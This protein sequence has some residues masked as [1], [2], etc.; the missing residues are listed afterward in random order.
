MALT[1]IIT[2]NYSNFRGVD[3][4]NDNAALTRSPDAL[5][6][7]RNYRD[8]DC[9]QTRPGMKLLD[10]FGNDI[11]GLF[12]YEKEDVTEVLIHV[13]TKILR[14]DNYPT[15][16]AK[17]TELY[18]GMN[19]KE[20]SGFICEKILYILDGINYLEYDGTEVTEVVGD[21]P[22]TTYFKSPDGSTSLDADTDTDTVF[23]PINLL[24][25]L[26]KN[27]FVADGTSVDYVLDAQ[28]LDAPAIYLMIAEVNGVKKIENLDFSVDRTKGIV[29]FKEAPEKGAEVYITYSKTIP[30]NREIIRQCTMFAEFDNRIFFSG[31]PDY[32]AVVFTTEAYKPRYIPETSYWTCGLDDSPITSIVPGNGALWAL[33]NIEQNKAS[34]HYLTPVVSSTYVKE[35]QISTGTIAIGCV[36]KGINFKDDIVFFSK[37]G[38]EGVSSNSIYSEQIL[39]HRSGLVDSKMINESDYLNVKIA[40]Y[41]N[42]LLCLIGSHIYLADSY[43]QVQSN[44]G[45][46]GYEWF[47]WEMPY[48]ITFMKEHL[49]KLYL[50]NKQG[51]LFVLEG[52]TDTGKD[53]QSH[54]TTAKDNFGYLGYTKTTNKR[55]NVAVLKPMNNDN[56]KLSTITDGEEQ[57]KAIISDA[58]GYTPFRIK[59][60]K[61]AQIQIKLSSNKPF[62]LFSCT[63]QG[64][65]AGYIKR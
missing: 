23:Q 29:T 14:W 35:Y 2:R 13:G 28:E 18:V 37:N 43:K 32:P 21:I 25:P 8:D 5:N 1:D 49:G 33:T 27:A 52:T 53:I 6:M 60:K 40:E 42:Y 3:F 57:E 36:S 15:T 19:I 22:Q 11:L 59:D 7:W 12:F 55:G 48:E 17:T 56:I 4:T 54:W 41:E 51:Q 20:S 58:K 61:F 30:G 24:T 46:I 45:E 62:G 26:A 31:N 44:T 9:V 65:V 16:P 64:F 34:V 38:L 39:E 63:T 10:E 50:G 47:Y